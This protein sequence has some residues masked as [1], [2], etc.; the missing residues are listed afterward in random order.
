MSRPLDQAI[1]AGVDVL[2]FDDLDDDHSDN[3]RC[4]T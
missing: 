2:P 1:P 4:W 3:G